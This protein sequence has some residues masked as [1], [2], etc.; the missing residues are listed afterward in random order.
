MDAPKYSKDAPFTD[1][2]VR[3]DSCAKL[4][5]RISIQKHGFCSKCGFKRVRA[6]NMMTE[7]ELSEVKKWGI[8][9]DWIA[10]FEVVDE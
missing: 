2:V 10:L 5:Q 4:V 9:P 6:V 3:C 1:P 8:D 7:E